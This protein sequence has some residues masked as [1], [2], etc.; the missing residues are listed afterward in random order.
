MTT[1]RLFHPYA[2]LEGVIRCSLCGELFIRVK[3]LKELRRLLQQAKRSTYLLD[4]PQ[5][6][7]VRRRK[8]ALKHVARG[9][10]LLGRDGLFV[11]VPKREPTVKEPTA[12][13]FGFTKESTAA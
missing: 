8:H 13:D 10:A 6:E 1:P 2:D 12:K 9:E 11:L 3:H 7:Q 5:T 4:K